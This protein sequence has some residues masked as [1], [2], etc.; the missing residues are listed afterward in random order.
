MHFEYFTN[1]I[2]YALLVALIASIPLLYLLARVK[3]SKTRYNHKL[4]KVELGA[5]RSSLE[6][7][8]YKINEKFQRD[9]KKW[10]E[11]N[12]LIMDGNSPS[13]F[14]ANEKKDA[15]NNLFDQH[16]FINYLG[17]NLNNISLKDNKV[18][19]ITPFN[20]AHTAEYLTIKEACAMVGLNCVRGDE[21]FKHGNILRHIIEEILSSKFIIAN[22]NGR[23]PNVFYEI[24][25]AQC[26][27]KK[28]ILISS[29]VEDIPFDLK[30]ERILT[31]TSLKDLTGKLYVNLVK[32]KSNLH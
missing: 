19:L 17:I 10:E 24:G 16:H 29:S 7:S 14:H 31:F 9:P 3:N 6:E 26:L 22:L 25:I 23:N 8:I 27:G 28:V 15:N 5:I 20:E 1:A 4:K 32:I 12:H 13:T 11:L 2:S 18:F 30:S 21:I